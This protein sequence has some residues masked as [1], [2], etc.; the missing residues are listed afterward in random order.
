MRHPDYPEIGRHRLDPAHVHAAATAFGKL[1]AQA[2]VPADEALEHLAKA[3]RNAG[4]AGDIGGLR[5]RL[6]AKVRASCHE[7]IAAAGE[8]DTAIRK[9]VSPYLRARQPAIAAAFA[10]NEARGAPLLPDT[11]RDIVAEEEAWWIRR[12]EPA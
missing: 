4:Y 10:E 8:A 2:L 6:A 7:W 5:S 11:V 3:A 9:V 1:V 12:G